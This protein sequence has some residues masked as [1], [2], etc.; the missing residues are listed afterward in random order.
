MIFGDT[1]IPQSEPL[2]MDKVLSDIQEF[3][4][5]MSKFDQPL[6]DLFSEFGGNFDRGDILVLS[7]TFRSSIDVLPDRIKDRIKISEHIPDGKGIS[8]KPTPTMFNGA[9]AWPL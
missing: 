2:T 3:R 7:E 9:T 5:T 8:I 6:R 4:E 1:F